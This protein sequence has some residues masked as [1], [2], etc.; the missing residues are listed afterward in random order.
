[1]LCIED[2]KE[3]LAENITDMRRIQ[4]QKIQELKDL[5]W[6]HTEEHEETSSS[7]SGVA[8]AFPENITANIQS[9]GENLSKL[10]KI[11]G[12][13]ATRHKKKNFRTKTAH[14][15]IFGSRRMMAV[16]LR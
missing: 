8:E 3:L 11:Y 5:Q 9:E 16:G 14:S 4:D 7:A 6:F 10:R 1:M 15:E 12:G 13:S 2:L